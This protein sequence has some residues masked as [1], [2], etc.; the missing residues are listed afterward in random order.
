MTHAESALFAGAPAR[1]APL[2]NRLVATLVGALLVAAASQVAA[3]LRG[4]PVPVTLQPVA[5]IIVGGLLGP[6]WGAASLVLYLAMG[7]AGLPVF[8]PSATLP[9]GLGRLFGPSGGYLLAYP[10]AAA[11]TGLIVTRWRGSLTACLV[12]PACACA[13]I[14]AGGWAQLAVLSGDPGRAWAIGV[15]PFLLK[16]VVN[17]AVAGLVIRAFLPKTR[18]LQ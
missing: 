16:D 5:V 12:A 2:A 10:V 14:L 4:T 9:P 13:V 8:A 17:I 6:R 7:A 3:L 11:L 18:A 1:P 15:A